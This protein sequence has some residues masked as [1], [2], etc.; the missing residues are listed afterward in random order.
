MKVADMQTKHGAA[1]VIAQRAR[2]GRYAIRLVADNGEPASVITTAIP[3]AQSRIRIDE[4]FEITWAENESLR[5]PLLDTGLFIDTGLR[6]PT[7]CARAEVWRL[8]PKFFEVVDG[9]RRAA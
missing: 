7:G 9:L 4:F 6:E 3:G 5:E 1:Q 2:D 8:T